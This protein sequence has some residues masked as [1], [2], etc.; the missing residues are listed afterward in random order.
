MGLGEINQLFVRNAAAHI[1]Q[2]NRVAV[3]VP[4]ATGDSRANV[5]DLTKRQFM[6]S[7]S[8]R[9]GDLSLRGKRI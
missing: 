9:A 8:A 2:E 3:F 1:Y 6:M 5:R 7:S 4:F